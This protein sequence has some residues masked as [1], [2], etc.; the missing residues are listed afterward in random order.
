MLTNNR[1]GIRNRCIL[2]RITMTSREIFFRF[3]LIFNEFW[4]VFSNSFFQS[5]G[6]S[7]YVHTIAV[8]QVFVYNI[9]SLM[10]FSLHIFLQKIFSLEKYFSFE[11]RCY[12]FFKKDILPAHK[13]ISSAGTLD[14]LIFY[15]NHGFHVVRH[16]SMISTD[17]SW[18][19]EFSDETV[20]LKIVKN[21]KSY[22]T[23]STI[24]Y[25]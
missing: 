7:T 22:G 9:T 12:L 2:N 19:K 16:L 25:F 14:V 20:L 10:Y 17:K 13:P 5:L 3:N 24:G 18:L 4:D 21:Q 11:K 8:A 23:V 15:I 1:I 6:R